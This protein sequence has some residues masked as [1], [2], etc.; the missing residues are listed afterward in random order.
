MAL[1]ALMAASPA[2]ALQI[3]TGESGVSLR[4]D[5]TVKYS[6]AHRLK[7]A[8]PALTNDPN[9]GDG[10]T[11]FRQ[12]GLIS[13]RFD[14]LSE[15]DAK[16]EN[17]GLRL[18]GAAWSDAIYLRPNR[19]NTAGAFGP[20]T[21][22]VN[23]SEISDPTQFTPYTR[24]THGRNA[25]VL[26]AFVSAKLDLGGHAATVRLGQLTQLW[27]ETLF[28]G[29]NGIAG[30]MSPVD[31]AKALSVPNLRFQEVM[32]PVPQLTGQLQINDEITAYAYYQL[33]WKESRLPGSDSYFSPVDFG[34][35]GDMILT[36]GGPIPRGPRQGEKDGGQGGLALRIRSEETDFGIYLARYHTKSPLL[37]TNLVNNTY[38]EYVHKGITTLGTSASRSFGRANLAMEASVRNNQDLLSPN[39]YDLGAGPQYA[40]GRSAH[41][42][43]SAFATSLG[44][45]ALWSDAALLAEVAYSRVLRIEKNADTMS[46]CQPAFLPGAVCQPNGTKDSLR[47]QV[48]FEPVYFQV[49]PGLELRVPIGLAYT[50]KG[51]RNMVGPV[52]FAENSGSL[53]V[54]MNAIY[55]DAWRFGVNYTHYYGDK[56]VAFRPINASFGS[57]WNYQQTSADRDYLSFVVSRTF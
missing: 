26:D 6:S 36:P 16:Y 21:S 20:G 14:L 4:W 8:D 37:I 29:D 17:F 49:L 13:S 51:T 11:N 35:G 27:G 38:Y 39:A 45:T 12:K 42:N 55:L 57:A 5:N 19:N 47:A 48:L 28:L 52:A 30:A 40:T 22:A 9:Q 24:K 46:G 50:L 15:I 18:S 53:S 7:D 43:V 56:G 2:G 54:G 34:A 33:R 32:R 44:P 23:S 41:A 25:E 31:V 3:D 10:D 1:A